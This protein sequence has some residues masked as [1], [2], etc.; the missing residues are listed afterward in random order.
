MKDLYLK[1]ASEQEAHSFL[2]S[3]EPIT[4]DVE[5][6]PVEFWDKPK[7]QNIDVVGYLYEPFPDPLPEDYTPVVMEGWHVNIRVL[8]DEDA[9]ELEAFSVQP[10]FPQRVWA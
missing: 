2:Y 10:S 7:Y 8:E 4:F 9:S 3:Q 6:T 5:G 1:F